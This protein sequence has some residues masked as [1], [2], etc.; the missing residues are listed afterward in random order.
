MSTRDKL[1]AEIDAYLAA[2]GINQSDFGERAM[3]NRSFVARLRHGM[4]ITIESMDKVR[5]WMASHPLDRPTP[6]KG[7]GL[8]RV[9]PHEDL[10]GQRRGKQTRGAAALPEPGWL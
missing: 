8:M 10:D 1:L 5:A 7:Q 6:K 9:S 4:N 3:G 2:S